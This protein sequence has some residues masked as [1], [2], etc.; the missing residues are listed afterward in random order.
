MPRKRKY[1]AKTLEAAVE[2]YF[3]SI[4]FSAVA[5]LPDGTEIAND[6]GQPVVLRRWAAPPT[7]GGLCLYLGIDRRT[8]CNYCD[9]RQ[10]PELREITGRARLIMETWL[11]SE[12]CTRDKNVQGLI[13][14]LQNN[15]GWRQRQEVDIGEETRRDL[16]SMSLSQ[17][18]AAIATA[19]REYRE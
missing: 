15:Y 1:N 12:L 5:R 11:E 2:E 18:L 16:S 10:H 17:K 13:F 9:A 6:A 14:S 19:A 3:D 8:W 4:S 7:V